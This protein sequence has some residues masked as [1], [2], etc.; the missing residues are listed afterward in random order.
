MKKLLLFIILAIS[1]TGCWPWPEGGEIKKYNY[2]VINNSGV[3]VEVIPYYNDVKDLSNKVIIINSDK[4]NF[5]YTSSPPSQ[6]FLRMSEVPF[7]GLPTK[8]NLTGIEITFNNSKKIIYQE[9][10]GTNQCFNQPRNIFNPIFSDE[11]TETYII[12]PEDYQNAVDCG[13]NCN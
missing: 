12:T 10:T 2:T 13:G 4:I 3:T 5:K 1:F 9:C 7:S 6:G 8:F 11:Q